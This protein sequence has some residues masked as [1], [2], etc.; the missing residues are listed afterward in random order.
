M[1]I[2]II[3]FAEKSRFGDAFKLGKVFRKAFTSKYLIASILLYGYTLV[4][5]FIFAILSII[6]TITIIIPLILVS[7]FIVIIMIT[8]MTIFGEVYSEIK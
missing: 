8:S 2:A 3:M 4:M 6:T 5:Q 7:V 1:P